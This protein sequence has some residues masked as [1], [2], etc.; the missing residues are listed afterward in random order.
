MGISVSREEQQERFD[1]LVASNG[2]E[3]EFSNI[4]K[5]YYGLTL[6]QF[7]RKIYEPQI[8][9]EKVAEAINADE[10]ISA[11]AK[12]QAEDVYGKVKAE[13]SDFSALAKEYSQDPGSAAMGGDLGYFSKGKMVPEFEEAAFKLK[14]NEVSEPVKSVY[15]YHIIKVTNIR[16]EEIQASHILI[17]VR[18][19]NEWLQEKK[20]ELREKRHLGVIP[21]IWEI[22][23]T[24]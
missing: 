23:S 9:R 3:E 17:K 2:G 14:K 24:D 22:I 7:R 19:F 4:L 15:G 16:G 8:L 18:D 6:D 1:Q 12:A 20:E 21:G 10:E 11:A 5:K 13:G